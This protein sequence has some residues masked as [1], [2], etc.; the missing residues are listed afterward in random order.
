MNP[1]WAGLATGMRISKPGDPSEQ[2]ADR[3]ADTVMS[4][5]SP[6]ARPEMSSV[7]GPVVQRMCSECEDE[8]IHRKAGTESSARADTG[9]PAE[10]ARK[11]YQETD[12]S[13]TERERRMD[14]RRWGAEPAAVLKGRPTKRDRR[15]LDK[16]S[17]ES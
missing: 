1:L 8:M 14:L 5:L 15:L 16:L 12:A 9:G 4:G 11:L 13:R 17:E 7:P 6:E 2:E 10:Q 3:I